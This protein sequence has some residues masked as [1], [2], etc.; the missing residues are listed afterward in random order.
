MKERF[1]VFLCLV[2]FV[3]SCNDEDS[4]PP[5]TSLQVI[6]SSNAEIGLSEDLVVS[7]DVENADSLFALSFAL[8]YDSTYLKRIRSLLGIYLQIHIYRITL[9]FYQMV[10]FR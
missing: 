1:I 2:V 6:L 9:I 4:I 10:K 3:C 7:I 8:H 5:D